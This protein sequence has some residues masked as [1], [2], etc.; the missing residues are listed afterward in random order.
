MSDQSS[1]GTLRL[2]GWCLFGGAWGAWVGFQGISQYSGPAMNPDTAAPVFV[3]GMF[4]VF[5]AIGLFAGAATA[6]AV[7]SAV[8]WGLRRL[9]VWP[10]AAVL[11]AL[12]VTGVA[13]WEMSR[14]VQDRYPG[15]RSARAAKPVGD[16]AGTITVPGDKGSASSPCLAPPPTEQSARASWVLE[17]G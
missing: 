13:L 6:S 10:V 11:M 12:M 5:A 4:V 9:G 2:I 3:W 7:G 15:L 8:A 16:H 1:R 14:L 17:C